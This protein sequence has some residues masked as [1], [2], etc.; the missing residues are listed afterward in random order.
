MS[1]GPRRDASRTAN[2]SAISHH[3]GVGLGPRAATSSGESATFPSPDGDG[4]LARSWRRRLSGLRLWAGPSS[5]A[6]G[7]ALCYYLL[8]GAGYLV[9]GAWCLVLGA[10]CLVL[11]AWCLVLGAR[12][13]ILGAWCSVLG[14]WYLVLGPWYSVLGYRLHGLHC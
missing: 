4:V 8:L 5:T 1:H 14:T 11:G 12:Y 3:S 7:W 13:L 9:L 2:Q 10:W 6:H